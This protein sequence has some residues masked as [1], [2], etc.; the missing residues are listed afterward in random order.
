MVATLARRDT[1][2]WIK[3][4]ANKIQHLT[5]RSPIQ[6]QILKQQKVKLIYFLCVF[7]CA[8]VAFFLRD[9]FFFPS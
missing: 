3:P 7:D 8:F 9:N 6:I 4:I 5:S 1:T 2:G